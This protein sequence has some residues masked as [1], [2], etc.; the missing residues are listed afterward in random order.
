MRILVAV[1]LLSILSSGCI[2]S[3]D[4]RILDE[5]PLAPVENPPVENPVVNPPIVLPPTIPPAD[6]NLT[7]PPVTPPVIPP[8]TNPTTI[9]LS[10]TE[11]AKHASKKN[12]WV[13]YAANVYNVSVYT[14]HPGGNVYVPYCGKDMTKAFDNQGHSTKADKIL[15]GFL[16]GKIGET[17]LAPSV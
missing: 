6:T 12:C 1:L 3:V 17:I 4:P 15:A 11:I 2:V 10:K 5:T 13:I 9:T 7:N 16:L 14:S 8:V